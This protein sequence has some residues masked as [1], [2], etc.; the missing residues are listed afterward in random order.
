MVVLP[1]TSS[2]IAPPSVPP[3]HPSTLYA[4]S[5]AHARTLHDAFLKGDVVG[6]MD[7]EYVRSLF[8]VWGSG[9][10]EIEQIKV[11][12]SFSTRPS[13][14]AARTASRARG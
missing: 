13:S 11:G 9:Y 8:S 3:R 4:P 6:N 5:H 12:S 14:I 7:E 1:L 10:E 2:S